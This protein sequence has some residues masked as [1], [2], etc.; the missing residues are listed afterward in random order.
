MRYALILG[1][2][3]ALGPLCTDFYLPSLPDVAAHLKISTSLSQLT[4][5]A[6]LIGLGLGQLIFGPISDRVGRK[7]PLLVSLVLFILSSVWCALSP[8][9][10]QLLI[11]RLLQGS[12]GAG[13][14]VISRAIARDK[15]NG[16]EL[17]RFFAILM[18][19]NGIAPVLA[20]VL[21]GMQLMVTGWQGL[22]VT[23][24]VIGI[25][26]ALISQL[27]VTESHHPAP[28]AKSSTMT[29]M[30][31]VCKDSVFM[32]LCFTQAFMLMGLFAYIGASAYVFQDIFKLSAQQ[33]SYIFAMNGIGL[34][35]FSL[36]SARIAESC[37]DKRVLEVTLGICILGALVLLL[38]A[39]FHGQLW[40]VIAALFIAVSINSSVCTIVGSLAMQRQGKHSGA[41]SALL[42]VM[43]F[44]LGGIA[45]PLTGIGGTSLLTMAVVLLCGYLLAAIT[46]VIWVR[47]RS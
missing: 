37:G 13:G 32:G 16:N 2:L 30:K 35:V 1:M 25:L 36:V 47:N 21:G 31:A 38:L 23:L 46:Y 24:A 5:T 42:G 27:G 17:T 43:M 20:P 11:A 7:K 41:A 14:A 15:Y 29:A 8:S 9:L 19:V 33:F 22:F 28:D 4:L 26:L 6:S 45:A 44:V 40:M 39:V 12:A 18:A 34:I 3:A 10:T